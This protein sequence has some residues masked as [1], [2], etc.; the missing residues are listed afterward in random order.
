MLDIN[1]IKIIFSYNNIC[2]K[3]FTSKKQ[4]YFYMKKIYFCK[5]K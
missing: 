2:I 5:C 4:T 1:L 3:C